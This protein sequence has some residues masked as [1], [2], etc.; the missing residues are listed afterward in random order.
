MR[1]T[2]PIVLAALVVGFFVAIGTFQGKSSSPSNLQMTIVNG[3]YGLTGDGQKTDN[4]GNS[5]YTDHNLPNGDQC[6]TATLNNS[7]IVVQQNY[8]LSTHPKQGWCNAQSGVTPRYWNIVIDDMVVCQTVFGVSASAPCTFN[9]S[10]MTSTDYEG[11]VPGDVFTSSS[12]QITMV[13]TLDGR[14]TGYGVRTDGT[15]TITG[16]G[17]TRTVT[18]NS[19]GQLYRQGE[20]TGT[21]SF[22]FPF[23]LIFKE[24]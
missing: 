17:N 3:N 5:I 19:T 24:L 15:A 14:T 18:Y 10:D 9:I 13:F 8:V 7:Y 22:N 12:S 23:Q 11:V 2:K 1:A 16:T 6:V 21:G 4:Y 20:P